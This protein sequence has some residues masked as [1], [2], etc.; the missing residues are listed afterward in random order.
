MLAWRQRYG[1]SPNPIGV[2]AQAD[3]VLLPM[4]EIAHEYHTRSGGRPERERLFNL[5]RHGSC[6]FLGHTWLLSLCWR[7]W[8]FAV[9]PKPVRTNVHRPAVSC[10]SINHVWTNRRLPLLGII[11][12]FLERKITDTRPGKAQAVDEG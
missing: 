3:R 10:N 7:C 8:S 2:F 1:G 4:R 6:Q 11:L 12:S 5:C 9:Q